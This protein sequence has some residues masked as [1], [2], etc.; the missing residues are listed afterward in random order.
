MLNGFFAKEYADEL[1]NEDLFVSFMKDQQDITSRIMPLVDGKG[2]VETSSVLDSITTLLT[3]S[4]KAIDSTLHVEVDA[5][6]EGNKYFATT[7]QDFTDVRLVFCVPKSMGKFGGETDNWMWP[8][9]TCDFSVFR[10]YADPKTNGPAAYSE[11]NVPYRPKRWAKVSLQGYKEGD[12][13]MT[14]G[15]PG[16]TSRYLSSYGIVQRRDVINKPCVNVR[17]VKL[18]IMRKYMNAS[19]QA[20]IQYENKFASCANYWK[21]SIGMNKCIDSIGLISQK[22]DYE[23]RIKEWIKNNNVN[24]LSLIHI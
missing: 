20:R 13:A 2:F 17:D 3:D 15:Y 14:V 12:Y 18:A 24:D 4:V 8:R 7:Y 9:Q 10:V 5:F 11:N 22:Q 21:N 19:E 1:P 23:A 16:S 6:Y